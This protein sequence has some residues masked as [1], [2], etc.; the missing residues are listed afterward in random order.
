MGIPYFWWFFRFLRIALNGPPTTPMPRS[1][2]NIQELL[3]SFATIV[4][5]RGQYTK[6]FL[7]ENLKVLDEEV[8]RSSFNWSTVASMTKIS[9][10]EIYRWYHDTFQRNLYGAVS[11]EDIQII[12]AEIEKALDNDVPLDRSYQAAIKE[13]LSKNYHRNSFTVAFNN[14]K[15]IASA[16]REA[17]HGKKKYQVVRKNEHRRKQKVE[18]RDAPSLDL[19]SDI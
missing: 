17:E 3:E 9:R 5:A 13:M 1:N 19:D 4:A 18:V 11:H 16:K 6:E 14:Q 8:C 12:R 2:K 7:L 10:H 15:K